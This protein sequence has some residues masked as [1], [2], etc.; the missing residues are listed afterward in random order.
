MFFMLCALEKNSNNGFKWTRVSMV[1]KPLRI[2][3]FSDKLVLTRSY[4]SC[5]LT[6]S[7]GK[8]KQLYLHYHNAYDQ[9]GD[10]LY[11]W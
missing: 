1:T 4:E 6:R 5:S 2:F 8:I 7:R 10:T 11:N 9:C 3:T